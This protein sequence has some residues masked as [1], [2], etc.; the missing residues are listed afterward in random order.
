MSNLLLLVEDGVSVVLEDLDEGYAGEY[1]PDDPDDERLVR[2][3]VGKLGA[4]E[5]DN[6]SYCTG[7]PV[8]SSQ[9]LLAAF[10][11]LVMGQVKESVLSGQS[12]KDTCE[13]LT[14]ETPDSVEKWWKR[15]NA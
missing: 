11:R 3:T 14:W 13:R 15:P 8:D 9:E 6:A 1:N 2:F 10:A 7:I 5:L 12:F 4:G